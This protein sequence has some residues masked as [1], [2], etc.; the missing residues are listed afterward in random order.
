MGAA[1][2]MTMV[3]MVDYF[4]HAREVLI[5]PWSGGQSLVADVMETGEEAND[6]TTA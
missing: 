5:G 3:S 4:V 6:D 2:V 1:V